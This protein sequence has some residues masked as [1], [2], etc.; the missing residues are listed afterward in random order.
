ML[1]KM[2]FFNEVKDYGSI[3]TEDGER[4]DV[5]RRGFHPGEAPVGRCRDLPVTFRVEEG[6]NGREAVEVSIVQEQVHG[7]ARRR[8]SRG[9]R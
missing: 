2:V 6:E 7:R 1:G 5:Y 4:L 9:S 8:T 3:E